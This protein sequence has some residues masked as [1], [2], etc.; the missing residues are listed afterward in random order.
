MLCYSISNVVSVKHFL[1]I[2]NIEFYCFLPMADTDLSGLFLQMLKLREGEGVIIMMQKK[3]KKR[4]CGLIATD[5]IVNN[6]MFYSYQASQKDLHI[7]SC[8]ER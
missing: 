4:K 6:V 8:S 7:Q 5:V 3:N 1:A 2:F